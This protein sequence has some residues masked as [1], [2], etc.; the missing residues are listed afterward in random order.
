MNLVSHNRRVYLGEWKEVK[1]HHGCTALTPN[2][3]AASSL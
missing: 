3:N 1:G 2:E